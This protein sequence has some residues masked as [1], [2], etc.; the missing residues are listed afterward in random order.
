DIEDGIKKGVISWRLVKAIL[1]E[2]K[3]KFGQELFDYLVVE[4]EKR[5]DKAEFPVPNRD[6]AVSTYFRTRVIVKA[7]A[8]VRKAFL[9]NYD[10]IMA[11]TYDKEILYDSDMGSFYEVLKEE[12]NYKHV[13]NAKETL[14]LEL[15]G[16]NV[17]RFLLDTFWEAE[18]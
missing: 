10:S 13:Y 15:L 11:G 16:R 12:I 9:K 17:I 4:A 1:E 5:I 14:R 3:G 6:E 8:E 2:N 18:R 7:Q